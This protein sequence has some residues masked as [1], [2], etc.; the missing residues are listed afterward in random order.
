MNENYPE[1]VL[2][3]NPQ[4]PCQAIVIDESTCIGCN[5]CIEVCR[6]EVLVANPQVG[7]PPLVMYP[8]ECW[9]GGCCLG[10]CPVEGAITMEHP[11]T[12]RIG[13]IRKETGEF[14]RMGMINPPPQTYSLPSC[15]GTSGACMV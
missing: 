3:A 14:F 9:F 15:S 8:D 7:K 6:T 11:L 2:T 1:A 12:Q 10:V 13:W 5:A 4:T